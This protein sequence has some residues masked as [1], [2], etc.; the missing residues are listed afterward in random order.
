MRVILRQDISGLGKRGD[1]CE[2]KDGHA[3]NFLFPGNK[4]IKAT[5]GSV[6]QATAMRRSRDLRDAADRAAASTIA[7]TLVAK[8]IMITAKAGSEGR[9]F[10]SVTNGD[11]AAAIKDQTSIDIDKRKIHT[12]VIKT[13]GEHSISIKLHADV[14]FPV[15]VQVVPA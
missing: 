4:A 8:T 12:G 14:E 1:I 9:L 6:A 5:D 7:S 2:V 11:V 10:G 3:R 15:T 13:T